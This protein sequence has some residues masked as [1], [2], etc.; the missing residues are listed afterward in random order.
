MTSKRQLLFAYGLAFHLLL[1]A[2]I[3][4]AAYPVSPP[5]EPIRIMYQ[6][7][8]GK[9]LFDHQTHSAASGY[10]ASCYDCHHHPSD[11]ESALIGCGEC[12]QAPT[13]DGS[14][15]ESCLDCHD[16]EDEEIEGTE[17]VSRANAFHTQCIECHEQFEKGPRSGSDNCSAC[18][19]L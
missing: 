12:H 4:Y 14:L 11:D 13:E 5:D 9:V 3:C 19:V 17:M 15:P 7:N 8:A 18:H 2:V 16:E 1:V 6:T 10:G